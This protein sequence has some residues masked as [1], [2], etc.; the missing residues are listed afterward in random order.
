[1]VR[2]LRD[3]TLEIM[4]N[5]EKLLEEAMLLPE[6]QREELAARL[7]D[8]IEAPEGIS[9]DDREEI[10][11]RAAEARTGAPGIAWADLKRDL[12]K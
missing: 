7:L 6:D 4:Q 1:L 10:E 3:G 11:K 12:L 5:A 2:A 9:I 8:S